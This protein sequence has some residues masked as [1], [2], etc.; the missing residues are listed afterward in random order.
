[1]TSLTKVCVYR[2]LLNE[3]IDE[4]IFRL[5]LR[6]NFGQTCLHCVG[7]HTGFLKKVLF[8]IVFVDRNGLSKAAGIKLFDIV[9][10][11]T[12]RQRRLIRL[13]KLTNVRN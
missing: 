5:F 4:L 12:N 8:R 10:F 9:N 6:D 7:I 11:R 1:L 13:Q 3:Q 2:L